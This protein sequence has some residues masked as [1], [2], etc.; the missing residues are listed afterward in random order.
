[1]SNSQNKVRLQNL[2]RQCLA[3]RDDSHK[4]L[5]VNMGETTNLGTGEDHPDLTFSHAEADTMIFGIYAKLRAGYAHPVIID[6]E[7]TDV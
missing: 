5:W 6:S 3:N 4:I 1:M 2:V 7:D